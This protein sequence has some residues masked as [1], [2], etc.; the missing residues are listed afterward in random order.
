M[1]HECVPISASLYIYIY[2]YIYYYY[3]V[4]NSRS[5]IRND[6]QRP[7]TSGIGVQELHSATIYNAL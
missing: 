5:E 7:L 3:I 1:L 2:I 6:L 4:A